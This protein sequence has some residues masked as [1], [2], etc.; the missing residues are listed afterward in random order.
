MHIFRGRRRSRTG[1]ASGVLTKGGYPVSNNS[2]TAIM[3]KHTLFPNRG[4][5]TNSR[6]EY[7]DAALYFPPFSLSF[8]TKYKKRRSPEKQ[9]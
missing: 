7:T 9:T 2:D 5:K 1:A 3:T 4:Y 8:S 6:A